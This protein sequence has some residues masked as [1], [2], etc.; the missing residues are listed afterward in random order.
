MRDPLKNVWPYLFSKLWMGFLFVLFI[1]WGIFYY[2][3]ALTVAGYTQ[4]FGAVV[5]PVV[6]LDTI[7]R[8]GTTYF[9]AF[10]MVIVVQVV[11]LVISVI[12]SIA[13]SPFAM[14]FFGNLVDSFIDAR[15]TFYFNL[16][17]ACILGLS[18]FKCA[19]RL[20]ISFD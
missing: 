10:A 18:L 8:M 13:T 6:G 1:G 3:M 9:K 15:F 12:I 16:V 7:R 5:N 14:P 2:P 4:S 20:D 11:S 19:H 17:I